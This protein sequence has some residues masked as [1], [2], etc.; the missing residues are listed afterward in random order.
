MSFKG[1]QQTFFFGLL[2]GT[3]AVFLWMLGTY[4]LPVFWATVIAI[5]FYPLYEKILRRVGSRAGLAS[6]V[7]VGAVIVTVMLP[8]ALVITMVTQESITIYQNLSNGGE[9]MTGSGLIEQFGRLAEYAEPLGIEPA[10]IEDRLR[11]ELAR[12]AEG[13]AASTVAVGQSTF[14]LL[15]YIAITIYLLYFLFRDGALL[16]ERLGHYLPLGQKYEQRLFNRFTETTRGVV[17]GTLT[18]AIIQGTLGGIT[19]WL[20]GVSAP[21]LWGVVMTLLGII[22]AIGTPIVWFPAAIMLLLSGSIWQGIMVLTV[23]L[24]LVSTIDEFLRPRLVGRKAKLP[25]PVVLLATLGGIAS[26]GIS[27]FVVGPIMAAFFISLWA[28]FEEKYHTQLKKK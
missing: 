25:D 6:L 18:V 28:M 15:V 19:L 1:I 26:F 8:L 2:L 17:Q 21:V 24:F 4:L 22:P 20:A 13:L 10:A 16:V 7:T 23:G 14:A 12:L 27:G 5:I 11:T 9:S 3:T